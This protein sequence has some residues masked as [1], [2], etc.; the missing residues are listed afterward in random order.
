MKKTVYTAA[1]AL[2]AL[3]AL[4][5]VAQNQ[6]NCRQQQCETPA[7]GQSKCDK[8]QRKCCATPYA[9]VFAGLNL[10][11]EQ[12]QA[13]KN[14]KPER[15]ARGQRNDSTARPD[16]KQAMRDYLN[17]VKQI[18]TP[19]QYVIFLENVVVE[20]PGPRAKGARHLQGQHRDR[21][22]DRMTSTHRRHDRKSPRA[23]QKPAESPAQNNTNN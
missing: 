12:Q 23:S 8:G 11:A 3:C 5:A 15:P 9:E 2:A 21:A 14:L 7:C 16:R 10:T 1:I 17:G 19:E 22:Q 13:I 6:G 18:L 4:P 20:Q